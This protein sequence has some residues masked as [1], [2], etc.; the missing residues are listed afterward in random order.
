MGTWC[1]RDRCRLPGGT[2]NV[3]RPAGG[4]Y[5]NTMPDRVLIRS[6]FWP[7]FLR[8]AVGFQ[9]AFAL[10]VG[11]GVASRGLNGEPL[12]SLKDIF[13]WAVTAAL[14]GGFCLVLA[15]RR[16]N[17]KAAEITPRGIR[18]L[19]PRNFHSWAC[20]GTVRVKVGPFG[21]RWLQVNPDYAPPFVLTARPHDPDGVLDALERFAGPDHPLTQAYSTLLDK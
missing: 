15:F 19:D 2:K 14:L 13:S 21:N 12:A 4:T 18:P 9:F 5:F 11:T 8:W 6:R 17:F 7:R 10:L 1:V 16:R 20:L 3:C